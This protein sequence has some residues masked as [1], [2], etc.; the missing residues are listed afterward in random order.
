MGKILNK[1][2]K[3]EGSE[4]DEF[5]DDDEEPVAKNEKK[6]KAWDYIKIAFY[7]A[8]FVGG[9]ALM[10]LLGGLAKKNDDTADSET[11]KDEA[12]QVIDDFIEAAK[13][14]PEIKVT[15]F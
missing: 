3:S 1:Q 2:V 10:F 13:E 9:A 15:E 8:A 12:D 14:N 7:G 11:E 6:A 5:F 4:N